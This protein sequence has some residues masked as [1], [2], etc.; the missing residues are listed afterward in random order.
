MNILIFVNYF[1]SMTHSRTKQT[2]GKNLIRL[3]STFQDYDLNKRLDSS[4]YNNLYANKNITSYS[5][6]NEIGKLDYL[7]RGT[8]RVNEIT[9]Q[10]NDYEHKFKKLPPQYGS[11]QFLRIDGE[12]EKDLNSIVS[13]FKA[14][15]AYAFGYGSGVFQQSGYSTIDK[16]KSQI[17]LVFGV[18]HPAYFHSLNIRQNPHHYSTLRFFGTDFISR[19]QEI[20]AGIY[21]NPFVKI[22]GHEV[23]YGVVSMT[24]LLRELAT[25]E[26]FYLAGRLQK[27]VKVLKNDLRVQYW[28]QLNLRA[29]ATLAKYSL[30]KNN[31]TFDEL[32]FYK[33]IA[34][35]SYIGDIRY[36]L[37]G[38]N[39]KKVS[40]IVEKNLDNFRLYYQPIFKD[41][42]M[43]HAAYL[44][45]GF[46]LENAF[47]KLENKVSK[48]STLQTMKGVFSAGITKSIKYAWAKKM[49]ALKSQ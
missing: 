5:D 21:F 44:P 4:L 22:N 42:V 3:K 23:K 17:D 34:S 33:K 43:N 37:G 10:F 35:L 14:P 48:S 26:H 13:Y 2:I 31:T 27:P 19:F 7:E 12:L 8:K 49:K 30:L 36:T 18:T 9:S 39:P 20:G 32:Q 15:I 1:N 45:D 11:N 46:T 16:S 24:R 6:H 47:L 38:E 28:N 29:A 40:N 41:V 25:W